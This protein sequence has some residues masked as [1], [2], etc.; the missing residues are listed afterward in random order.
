MSYVAHFLKFVFPLFLFF[1]EANAAGG[2]NFWENKC[3]PARANVFQ[4]YPR[5]GIDGAIVVGNEVIVHNSSSNTQFGDYLGYGLSSDASTGA[6]S[7]L[8]EKV[9]GG[10]L[11]QTSD[12]SGGFYISGYF[13]F[14]GNNS[15]EASLAR[16]NSNGSFNSAVLA[17]GLVCPEL[18]EVTVM[19]KIGTA[20]YLGGYFQTMC[21]QVRKGLAAI[22]LASGTLSSWSPLVEGSVVSLES[23]GVDLFIG[24]NFTKV[25]DI[26]RSGL[27][28]VS[29]ST[30]SLQPSAIGVFNS[31]T[32]P[33]VEALYLD[34]NKLVVG[35]YFEAVTEAN[36]FAA[37]LDSSLNT[38]N[39][40]FPNGTV[41]VTVNDNSTGWFI[42][43]AF[44]KVGAL[45]RNRIARYNSD[46]TLSSWSVDIN[47]EVRTMELDGTT[48]YIGGD[49]TTVGG[50][51]RNRLAAI[52]ITTSTV[53]SWDPNPNGTTIVK[54]GLT[55]STVVVSG[56]FSEVAGESKYRF[57]EINKS[58]GL[59]TS[60][61][62]TISGDWGMDDKVTAMTYNGG[63]L[64]FGGAFQYVGTAVG[65]GVPTDA[66]TG[67]Q[68]ASSLAQVNGNVF[69]SIADGSGGWYIGG[70]FTKIGGVAR[71]RIA[72]INSDGSLNS[73]VSSANDDVYALA[74]DGT[75]LY[76]G[77]KFTQLGGQNRNRLGSVEISTGNA[78]SWNPNVFDGQINNI[79]FTSNSIYVAGSFTQISAQDRSVVAE[80]V[81]STGVLTAWSP[82]F[83]FAGSGHTLLVDGTTLYVGGGFYLDSHGSAAAF[84]TTTGAHLTAW[85]PFPSGM[86]Y[87]LVKKGTNILLGGSFDYLK[88]YTIQRNSLAEVDTIN[89]DPTSFNPTFDW[90]VREVHTIY[91]N[92]TTVYVGGTFNRYQGTHRANVVAF[93]HSGNLN[94]WNP[95]TIGRT[96]TISESGGK[97]YVGGRF[98]GIKGTARRFLGS[99]DL[100]T[101][102]VTSWDPRVSTF[103]QW[104]R[105]MVMKSKASEIYI[106]GSYIALNWTART[107][108]SIVDTS[109]TLSSWAPSLTGEVLDIAFNGSNVYAVG[110][111]P[112]AQSTPRKHLAEF[113]SG[114]ILTSWY[115]KA[116]GGG[117]P[118]SVALNGTSIM[119]G[120][121]FLAV[122]DSLNRNALASIDISSDTLESWAPVIDD[123]YP[124]VSEI[125]KCNGA[126]VV[127][128]SFSS[129][130]GT[131]RGNVASFNN[132][133]VLT[134]FE[135][136]TNDSIESM[137]VLGNTLYL[138][139]G[140]SN[141]NGVSRTRTAAVD[142]TTS[143]VTAWRVDLRGS[144]LGSG[145]TMY[146][147]GSGMYNPLLNRVSVGRSLGSI[148]PVTFQPNAWSPNPDSIVLSTHL[149]G[150]TL[151]V[152][153]GFSNI[154][155]TARSFLA[156]Y[157]MPSKTLLSFDAGIASTGNE[158]VNFL[159]SNDTNLYVAGTFTQVAGEPRDRLF[160]VNKVTGVLVPSFNPTFTDPY[161]NIGDPVNIA[162]VVSSFNLLFVTGNFL[163]VNG[164]SRGG[165]AIFDLST[166]TLS[167]WNPVFAGGYVTAIHA[168]NEKL[169]VAGSFATVNG[170]TRK[171]VARFD[172]ATQTLDSWSPTLNSEMFSWMAKVFKLGDAVYFTGSFTTFGG[173]S[174]DGFAMVSDATGNLYPETFNRN[175]EDSSS[176]N[177]ILSIGARKVI[178][179]TFIF[180][181]GKGAWGV[182]GMCRR[183]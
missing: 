141:V 167:S 24:G 103:Y 33:S 147:S 182:Y 14:V 156:A 51:P 35:G 27:A 40:E 129:S 124:L 54:L 176:L 38:L 74:I 4:K 52:D 180:T 88:G 178:Y 109:G 168:T 48:L 116:I 16:I 135:A 169:Y 63:N 61:N 12:D 126:Y 39:T 10:I 32:S 19:K 172:I 53:T 73:W 139:G 1:E 136:N 21:G 13:R 77:G 130:G 143:T 80:F 75:N 84:D 131:A 99:I 163:T 144:L 57:A 69:T 154:S 79:A 62:Q 157:S 173:Q 93:D 92:A 137:A 165:L 115:P 45:V 50:S 37:I 67:A 123:T 112:E 119:V 120:G 71:S 15:L 170:Q 66:S 64:Y 47:G 44:T 155:S 9:E 166:H 142:C 164:Q 127:G 181:D 34:G 101:K 90:F 162:N 125:N 98:R 114:G 17:T 26:S 8:N 55:P 49:F 65:A 91:A 87:S 138:S 76:V 42:A 83:Q 86:V 179:G 23:N 78:T 31:W 100:T 152:G 177:G 96:Q 128:G 20:L 95:D 11:A 85:N 149:S 146:V 122:T 171:G 41:W 72:R 174:R 29:L 150:S 132:S 159:T 89:G 117:V 68:S 22:H 82:P 107:N 160:A 133:G 97:I 105:V 102:T 94:S 5:S 110:N 140:F 58:D 106:G 7:T 6:I 175:G 81:K 151:F 18:S 30:G 183:E 118:W 70:S 134:S 148:D 56:D 25:N 2:I 111:I 113:D 28:R 145:S 104:D 161:N 3:D 108:L 153:G 121:Q 60:F 59:S 36:S 43:G 158:M 46:G